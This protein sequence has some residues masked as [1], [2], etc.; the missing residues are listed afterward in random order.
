M[1]WKFL[2]EERKSPFTGFRWP[3]PGAWVTASDAGLCD[4]GFHGCRR[5]DLPYWLTDE[6][7][8]VELAG[9]VVEGPH[10]VVADRARLVEPVGAWDSGT[11]RELAIACV[12]R[13]AY[14]AVEELRE[15]GLHEEAERIDTAD[16]SL[17]VLCATA[18]EIGELALSQRA[19]QAAK[20]CGYLIDAIK[21]IDGNPVAV[22]AYIA[23][24]AANQRTGPPPEADLYAEER[25]WQADW[26]TGRLGLEAP[27]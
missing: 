25:R 27:G 14:H 7:W 4:V 13:T 11:A 24:R 1:Y 26:L 12:H 9:K 19:R 23:A 18:Q 5:Q 8:R 21:W 10:K 17:P 6:L 3:E 20:L 22:T 16:R 15:A 2:R